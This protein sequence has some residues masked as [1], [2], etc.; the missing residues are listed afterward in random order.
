MR[1]MLDAQVERLHELEREHS[2]V[3]RWLF[4]PSKRRTSAES[5]T[6]ARPGKPPARRLVYRAC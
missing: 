6:C 5:T 4:P 3:I 2:R 1:S